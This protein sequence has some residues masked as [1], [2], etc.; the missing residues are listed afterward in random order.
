MPAAEAVPPDERLPNHLR[1]ASG[2]RRVADE[3]GDN[4]VVYFEKK[5]DAQEVPGLGWIKGGSHTLWYNVKAFGAARAEALARR[6]Q[7]SQYRQ[8][9]NTLLDDFDMDLVD[10][11]ESD[12]SE[13]TDAGMPPLVPAP[14]APFRMKPN[15][16]AKQKNPSHV[17]LSNLTIGQSSDQSDTR[18]CS[19]QIW[20]SI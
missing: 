10:A 4:Y 15:I 16:D 18:F 19:Y 1:G 2:V 8:R 13:A 7:R 17:R 9:T 14:A 6:H 12:G 5:M 3:R 20:D 11:N